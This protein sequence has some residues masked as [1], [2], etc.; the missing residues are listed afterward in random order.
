VNIWGEDDYLT[1]KFIGSLF[2]TRPD[3]AKEA[4][5]YNQ[6]GEIFP[7]IGNRKL[8]PKEV[9]DFGHS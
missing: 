1:H 7:K 2:G 9:R 5:F 6:D 4:V 3:E 8:T